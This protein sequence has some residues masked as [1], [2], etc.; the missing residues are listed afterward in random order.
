MIR[1]STNARYFTY[2]ITYGMH[3]AREYS[4][5]LRLGL[6]GQQMWILSGSVCFFFLSVS[7]VQTWCGTSEKKQ[8]CTPRAQY[9]FYLECFCA[10][11]DPRT[12]RGRPLSAVDES[13]GAHC[14]FLLPNSVH[15]T[16][17]QNRVWR[18]NVHELRKR[19]L[20]LFHIFFLLFDTGTQGGELTLS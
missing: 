9:T 10:D 11:A 19:L 8:L 18:T 7:R 13:P 16:H 2:D 14:V 20:V 12:F 5:R 17:L 15:L 4:Y 1:K 3:I 6:I